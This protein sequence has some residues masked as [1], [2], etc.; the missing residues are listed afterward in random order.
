MCLT[1]LLSYLYTIFQS[2]ETNFDRVPI[3][4]TIANFEQ[5]I[6]HYCTSAQLTSTSIIAHLASSLAQALHVWPV[7]QYQH[8]MSGQQPSTSITCL[9]SRLALALLHVY[10]VDQ[11]Y[12]YM[13]GQ[14]TNISITCLASRL[15]L[16]I[17]CM[18]SRLALA[19]H[20]WPVDQH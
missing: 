19:L 12:H 16:P 15:A 5:Q 11:H 3:H 14:Q 20:I 1:G 10:P 9:A 7:A 18:A 13:S 6:M 4:K 2:S 17:T 8:Y